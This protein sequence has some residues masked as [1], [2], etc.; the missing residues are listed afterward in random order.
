MA[1]IS[2]KK[3]YE[4]LLAEHYSWMFGDF[5]KQVK[6]NQNWFKEHD[7][8][9]KTNQKAIDLGCGSGFQSFALSSIGFNVTG[10]DFN[11]YLL[12]ELK[13]H[14]ENETIEVIQSDILKPENYSH[15][16]PFELAVCMG[17]TL[18]HLSSEESVNNFFHIAYN[19]LESNGKLII[20]FR[21][22]SVE[23]TGVDRFVPVQ[24]DQNKIMTVFLEYESDYLLVHDLVYER[25]G[26]SWEF[27]KSVYKKVRL[28]VD[29][30][31]YLLEKTN[32]IIDNLQSNQGMVQIIAAK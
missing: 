9:P 1:E 8:Y 23:L 18:T 21:D 19:L 31:K 27:E 26:D 17:D 10:I 11:E 28:S 12:D 30:V 6:K 5:N 20:G 15:M 16:A 25:N 13:S 4:N 3:H 7:V 14:D 29:R 2:A 32:F 22:Y 24:N